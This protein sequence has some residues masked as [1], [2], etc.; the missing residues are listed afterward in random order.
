MWEISKEHHQLQVYDAFRVKGSLAETL[1]FASQSENQTDSCEQKWEAQ[2]T[3]PKQ[4]ELWFHKVQQVHGV[5]SSQPIGNGPVDEGHHHS[6]EAKNR[7]PR[8][9]ASSALQPLPHCLV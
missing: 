7:K 1:G 6:E 8:Q 4:E 2:S 5:R 3:Y 9:I